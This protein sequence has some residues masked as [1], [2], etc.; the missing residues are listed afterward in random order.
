VGETPPPSPSNPSGLGFELGVGET[1]P[2]LP[3]QPSGSGSQ[4]QPECRAR[5]SLPARN[6]IPTG[7]D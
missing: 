6:D 3:E 4:K 1:P 7:P 5:M 2:P